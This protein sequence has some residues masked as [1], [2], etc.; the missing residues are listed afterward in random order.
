MEYR[1]ISLVTGAGGFV[2]RHLVA[3]LLERGV[4]VRAMA[5][6]HETMDDLMRRGV[7]VVRADLTQPATLPP[8]FEGGVDRVF[9]CAA[10]CNL[11][12]PYRVLRLV[13]VDG[14]ER[15]TSLALA[16]SVRSF[17]HLSSTSVYGPYRGIPFREDAPRQ[18]QDSYGRSKRDGEAIVWQRAAEG[19]RVTVLRPCTV[20]GPGCTDGAGKVFSRPTSIGAVPGSGSQRLSNVRV[21]DVVAAAWHLSSHEDAAGQAFNIADDSHPAIGAALAMAA[22]AFGARPPRLHLPLGVVAAVARMQG[23][24]ARLARRIPDLELD[25]VRYL[26]GDYV[27]DNSRLKAAGYAL[28]YPDFAESMRDMAARYCQQQPA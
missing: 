24:A 13:N 18:P 14:V 1:G 19:L 10:I 25:A 7:D 2:G 15:I 20:Y 16:A 27:V 21:E 26:A 28:R 5:L 3:L 23:F 4:R 17:V 6:P 9:H 12:T 11:S 22:Q 8:L